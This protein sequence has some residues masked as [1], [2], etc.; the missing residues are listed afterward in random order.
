MCG[1]WVWLVVSPHCFSWMLSSLYIINPNRWQVP[2]SAYFWSETLR[3]I[4][5]WL[6]T[7]DTLRCSIFPLL[8]VAIFKLLLILLIQNI[9][10]PAI[11]LPASLNHLTTFIA[12]STE[13]KDE[14][15]NFIVSRF[16]SICYFIWIQ[17]ILFKIVV[18]SAIGLG[19]IQATDLMLIRYSR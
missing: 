3:W 12:I 9:P 13:L 2:I 14:S 19:T 18:L 4:V 7:H 11:T 8:T 17:L 1:T 16:I 6:L 5:L 10:K 15:L